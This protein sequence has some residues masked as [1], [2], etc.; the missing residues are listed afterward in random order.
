MSSMIICV[1]G[2]RSCSNCLGVMGADASDGVIQIC[3]LC[4]YKSKTGGGISVIGEWLSRWCA[5]GLVGGVDTLGSGAGPGVG[6]LGAAG[7][8]G[9]TWL[10]ATTG[11]SIFKTSGSGGGPYGS[12]ISSHILTS[13]AKASC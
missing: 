3:H 13:I 4:L 12:A 10:S 2:S 11:D 8:T 9:S 5:L 1:A 6:T 7:P